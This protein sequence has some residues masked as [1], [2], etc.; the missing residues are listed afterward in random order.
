[1]AKRPKRDGSQAVAESRRNYQ[2][3]VSA[4]EVPRGQP[5]L[6]RNP[7]GM[8]RN[9]RSSNY[10][11]P[12]W[13]GKVVGSTSMAAKYTYVTKSKSRNLREGD[14][15]FSPTKATPIEALAANTAYGRQFARSRN[16]YYSG[17]GGG[18][19]WPIGARG[20]SSSQFDS[21]GNPVMPRNDSPSGSTNYMDVYR[22]LQTPS[23][24]AP[25]TTKKKG[26]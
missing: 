15:S 7:V 13:L 21:K 20:H 16:K 24:K 23:K 18:V 10:G 11:N 9:E 1:M 2:K 4:Y 19:S 22:A 12:G 3:L 5:E 26:K 8:S 14:R 17:T 25:K 6:M